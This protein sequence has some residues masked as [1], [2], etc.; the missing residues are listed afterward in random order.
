[1]DLNHCIAGQFE[2]KLNGSPS[3]RDSIYEIVSTLKGFGCIFSVRFF[4]FA[5]FVPWNVGYYFRLFS[6]HSCITDSQSIKK[7]HQDNN[8]EKNKCLKLSS[9][10]YNHEFKNVSSDLPIDMHNS[11]GRCCF[12]SLLVGPKTLFLR[13]TW[14]WFWSEN[15]RI[16][17]SV[18]NR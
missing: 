13:Q 17:F 7:I 16:K 15:V 12:L 3:R 9:L 2:R 4:K 1:M 6:D 14:W 5:S 18:M 11:K 8:Y 10:K